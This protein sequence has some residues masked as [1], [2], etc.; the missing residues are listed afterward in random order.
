MMVEGSSLEDNVESN[1]FLEKDGEKYSIYNESILAI[2]IE[3]SQV[4]YNTV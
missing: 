1:Y 2:K 4:I 3:Y